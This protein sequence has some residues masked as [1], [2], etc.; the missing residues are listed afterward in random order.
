MTKTA[1]RPKK[2]KD[3]RSLDWNTLLDKALRAGRDYELRRQVDAEM[4]LRVSKGWIRE[5]YCPR[6][7]FHH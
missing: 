6:R 3:L 7:L 4:R 1:D 5:S 2:T